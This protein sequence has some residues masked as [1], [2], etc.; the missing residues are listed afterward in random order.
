MFYCIE[1]DRLRNDDD[2]TSS[3]CE[4]EQNDVASDENIVSESDSDHDWTNY[5]VFVSNGLT[6]CVVCLNIT[7][8][9][10]F[11]VNCQLYDT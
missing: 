4:N 5:Y 11:F 10:I 9:L 2:I 6:L 7:V 8:Y 1:E 3:D